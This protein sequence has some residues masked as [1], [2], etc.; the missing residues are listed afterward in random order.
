M[1]CRFANGV[2]NSKLNKKIIWNH[3]KT[4]RFEYLKKN[5]LGCDIIPA[6]NDSNILDEFLFD[7]GRQANV[8]TSSL[9]PLPYL[10]SNLEAFS[11]IVGK[12]SISDNINMNF[13]KSD[14]TESAKMF[15]TLN[16]C[17]SSFVKLYWKAIYGPKERMSMLTSNI[18][19]KAKGASKEVAQNIF[20]KVSAV[21]GFQYLS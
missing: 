4:L 7:D 6:S 10:S 19:K 2:I 18:I 14:I 17:P 20:A 16:S 9:I 1:L 21:L 8:E 12:K 13:S 15:L 5:T 3:I 11:Q